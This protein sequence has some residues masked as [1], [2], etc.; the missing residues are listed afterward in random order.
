MLNNT[1]PGAGL[2]VR[3]VEASF[4]GTKAYHALYLPKDWQPATGL[5]ARP[6][7]KK[8]P[9]IVEYMGNG[10]WQDKIGDVSTGRPEDANLGYGMGM[11]MDYIWISMPFL[12]SDMGADTEISTYWWGCP[13]V[14][15]YHD[16]GNAYNI[17]PTMTY[18]HR[19]LAHTIR[20]YGGDE[21]RVVI[22]GWSR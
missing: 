11:G 14:T 2:R 10:P 16:C 9:V 3:A 13:T 15:A 19:S 21:D 20:T 4:A 18:L 7:G 8:Y 1:K 6:A 22:T 12:T 5:N 17:T